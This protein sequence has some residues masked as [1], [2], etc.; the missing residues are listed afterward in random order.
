MV[1]DW[2]YM[3][4]VWVNNFYPQDDDDDGD[5]GHI[6]PSTWSYCRHQYYSMLLNHKKVLFAWNIR[7]QIWFW[8]CS[9]LIAP[10]KTPLNFSHDS[11]KTQTEQYHYLNKLSSFYGNSLDLIII[12]RAWW[13][14]RGWWCEWHFLLLAV[15]Q[16]EVFHRKVQWA[17]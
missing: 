11:I 7:T 8:Y 1:Q 3:W 9:R 12:D 6:M 4:N 17:L 15:T 5:H 2:S 16:E 14:W 10:V 13:W